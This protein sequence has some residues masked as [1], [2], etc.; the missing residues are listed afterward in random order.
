MLRWWRSCERPED[1]D[2]DEGRPTIQT[3]QAATQWPPLGWSLSW[4]TWP[5][6]MAVAAPVPIPLAPLPQYPLIS[7]SVPLFLLTFR[8][9][10]AGSFRVR[11]WR[12][13]RHFYF[14]L[15]SLFWPYFVAVCF[16][17]C[18]LPLRHFSR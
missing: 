12:F 6:R 5:T 16:V 18:W 10:F 4:P 9:Q 7:L 1:G 14:S 15:P 17:L 13:G 3:D 11:V 2:E 8:A